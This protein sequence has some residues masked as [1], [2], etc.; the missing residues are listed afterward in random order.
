MHAIAINEKR[1]YEFEGGAYRRVWKEERRGGNTV[2]KIQLKNKQQR[3]M[4]LPAGDK[5]LSWH[6][7][8][9]R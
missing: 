1:G 2:I 7:L 8:Q 9:Y 6:Q 4:G 5:R 3:R